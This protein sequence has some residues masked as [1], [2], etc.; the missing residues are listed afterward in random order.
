MVTDQQVRRLRMLVNKE[1]SKAIAAAKAGMSEKTARKYVKSNKLPSEKEKDRSWKTRRSPFEGDW[2]RIKGYLEINPGIEGSV[3]ASV[4]CEA[5]LY[6]IK[7]TDMN[8]K[9][10]VSG[11]FFIQL[12]TLPKR[13]TYK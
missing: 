7:S 4:F 13:T 10:F 5:I 9:I 3:I 12:L 6:P 2:C 8:K 11:L 1:R